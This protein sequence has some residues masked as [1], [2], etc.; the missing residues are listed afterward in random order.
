M[1][2]HSLKTKKDA[3]RLGR[4]SY[5]CI[6]QKMSSC[7]HLRLMFLRRVCG[8]IGAVPPHSANRE[9]RIQSLVQHDPRRSHLLPG[10]LPR[11][12]EGATVV[13][14]P[15][16]GDARRSPW[17]C[18]LAC[19][20]ALAEDATHL[21]VY[22]DDV[23]PCRDLAETV[24]LILRS[25]P[26]VP[27]ALFVPGLGSHARRILGACQDG[28]RYVELDRHTF[29]PTVAVVWPRAAVESILAFSESYGFG[30]EFTADDGNLAVWAKAT[31]TA[32]W[33]TVPS[34]IEHEDRDPSLVGKHHMAGR[35]P[36]R[37]AACWTGP[38]L[39]PLELDGW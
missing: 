34:L 35:N 20:R 3:L 23:T 5:T 4:P 33:A 31:G 39:S 22:Q 29:V 18:Y 6:T 9:L 27:L 16:A 36:A 11:L 26:D 24:E 28:Q 12:P 30:D 21:A 19:L 15:G 32:V 7:A 38:D 25:R 10:L 17:R 13:A 8:D 2:H 37:I 14:D 1:L